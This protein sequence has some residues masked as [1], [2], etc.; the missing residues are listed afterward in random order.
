MK[1]ALIIAI[2]DRHDLDRITL[3]RFKEQAAKFGFEI[4]VAGSE[5]NISKAIAKGCHYIEVPN[6]PLSNKHNALIKK[7]QEL[8]VDGVVLMGSDDM[9]NDEYWQW[10]LT[11]SKDETKLIGLSD[12]YFYSTY[13]KSLYYFDK[14]KQGQSIGAGRF[15][16]KYVL[17]KMEWKLWDNGLP[18]SLDRNCSERLHLQGIGEQIHSMDSLNVFLLDVKHTRSVTN[19]EIVN[20]CEVINIEIMAKKLGKKDADKVEALENDVQI[21]EEINFPFS[22]NEDVKVIGLVSKY[23]IEGEEYIV[24]GS[25]AK[26]LLRKKAVKLA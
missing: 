13:R 5:G 16:S 12:L 22:D 7:A 10:V 26:V 14:N 1:L 8:N 4:I 9:V 24:S 6:N 25:D 15:F 19:Q 3:S 23:L 11:L 17:D 21:F 18:K 20:N 2:Y